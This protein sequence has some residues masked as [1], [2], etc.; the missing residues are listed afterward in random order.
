VSVNAATT[1]NAA[2]ATIPIIIALLLPYWPRTVIVVGVILVG[3][4]FVH[5]GIGYSWFFLGRY[6]VSVGIPLVMAW[7]GAYLAAKGETESER[8]RW[9]LLFFML[10]AFALVGSWWLQSQQDEDHKHELSDFRIGVKSDLAADLTE[11]NEAHPNHQVTAE[12]FAELTKSVIARSNSTPRA[13]IASIEPQLPKPALIDASRRVAADMRSW[14]REYSSADKEL[15]DRYWELTHIRRP[16]L[17]K[18]QI[19]LLLGEE[20]VKRQQLSDQY[21]AKLKETIAV[22]NYLR[23][24][25]LKGMPASPDDT[26]EN[27]AFNT[28]VNGAPR[29]LDLRKAADYMDSLATRVI[30]A[31]MPKLLPSMH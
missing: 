31:P 24:Q 8:I 19:Q 7:A 13:I 10:T 25:M 18:D 20:K 17:T 11:Y 3:V 21:E 22:A 5:Y 29:S 12:Q 26:S 30:P 15:D 6:T 16:P 27:A 28:A 9:Q 2:I 23:L 14:Q 4:T 1:V